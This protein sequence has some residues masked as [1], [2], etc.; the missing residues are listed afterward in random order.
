MKKH[1][2]ILLAILTA[3]LCLGAAIPA[4]AAASDYDTELLV[5][6]DCENGTTG[7]SIGGGTIANDQTI[8]RGNSGSSIKFEIKVEDNIANANNKRLDKNFRYTP[9]VSG[10]TKIS[11]YIHIAS[12]DEGA[13]IVAR[14]QYSYSNNA[15][16]DFQGGSYVTLANENAPGEWTYFEINLNTTRTDK[17]TVFLNIYVV[18]TGACIYVDD[19]SA[20]N[21]NN[22]LLSDVTAGWD[23]LKVG[24]ANYGARNITFGFDNPDAVFAG[25]SGMYLQTSSASGYYYNPRVVSYP[26]ADEGDSGLRNSIKSNTNY[27]FS[28]WFKPT[29]ENSMPYIIFGKGTWNVQSGSV[30]PETERYA[31]LDTQSWK[32]LETREDGWMKLEACFKMPQVDTTQDTRMVF[33]S[34]TAGSYTACGSGYY[35]EFCLA[36]DTAEGL[37]A[38]NANGAVVTEAKAGDVITFNTHLLSDKTQA[39]GGT[40]CAIMLAAYD[41]DG[42]LTCV[43]IK[44]A[45]G[46]AYLNKAVT[47]TS[48]GPTLN[49]GEAGTTFTKFQTDAEDVTLTYTVP[50]KAKGCTIK[51]FCLKGVS[52][53]KLEGNILNIQVA[54][55]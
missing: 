29:A 46:N 23:Q 47:K 21:V 54:A 4:S 10:Y 13:Y 49:E 15:S 24:S 16:Y 20:K 50:E 31:T 40:P 35:D 3:M 22:C 44:V 17:T 45:E 5:N 41:G 8:R 18:G 33:R 11:G 9:S 12:L 34:I 53:L 14:A 38:K 32:V 19:F 2:A 37:M 48:E 55:E 26:L 52:S 43:D 30:N 36:E 42:T 39:E 27:R 25:N 7:W 51:A 1:L 28:L 6:G